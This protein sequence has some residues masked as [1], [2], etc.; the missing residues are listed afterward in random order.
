MKA[1]RGLVVSTWTAA[2][3]SPLSSLDTRT[4][5][6]LSHASSSSRLTQ[7]CWY[8]KASSS[9]L[10][11]LFDASTKLSQTPSNWAHL[12]C[13]AALLAW[14]LSL[15]SFL[16]RE[17]SDSLQDL[18]VESWAWNCW[19]LFCNFCT[20]SRSRPKLSPPSSKFFSLKTAK[21]LDITLCIRKVC[22]CSNELHVYSKLNCT[23]YSWI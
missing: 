7:N 6:S 14:G 16:P 10:F 13:I 5:F 23:F 21:S 4:V 15:V 18:W 2:R 17:R 19:W 12:S 8:S 9:F 11:L 1:A 22:T 20:L 3:V